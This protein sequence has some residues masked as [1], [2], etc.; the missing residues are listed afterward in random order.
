MTDLLKSLFDV[1]ALVGI[2]R[3]REIRNAYTTGAPPPAGFP[4]CAESGGIQMLCAN[5]WASRLAGGS[6]LLHSP[7]RLRQR[8]PFIC[9]H[10]RRDG[11]YRSCTARYPAS[12]NRAA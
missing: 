2:G 9:E 7:F 11:S 1:G 4:W 10:G 8:V 3:N 12:F 5:K 6:L